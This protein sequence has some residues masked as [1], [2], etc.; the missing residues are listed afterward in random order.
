MRLP[1]L[2]LVGLLPA[3]A[4]A[5]DGARIAASGTIELAFSPWDEPES[6]LLRA[7]GEA[8]ETILVQAYAFTSKR[9]AGALIQA[10]KR[11]VRVE[12]LADAKMHRRAEGN[13]LPQLVR[14][15]IPVALETRYAAAH[16]KV[17]VIDAAAANPVVVTGSYNL[18][19]SANRRNAENL[20]ILRGNRDLA[21]AYERNWQRHRREAEPV[22]AA[23]GPV[24]R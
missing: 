23:L 2:F 17:L 12:V 16:N 21:A 13:V 10:T 1:L 5:Q 7:I 8:R 22:D 9:I 18:T 11:G 6:A 14:S 3:A 20:L 19:W 4:G 15:G 24:G